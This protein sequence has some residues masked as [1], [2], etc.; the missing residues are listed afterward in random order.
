M[1]WPPSEEVTMRGET[2]GETDL[3]ILI[4]SMHPELSSEQYVFCTTQRNLKEI[5]EWHPWAIITE[6]EAITVIVRRET[7]DE[8][9]LPYESV[10]RRITL[11]VHSSLDAVGLT[12]A[13]S[14]KLTRSGISANMVAGYYHDH[15]FIQNE[16]ADVALHL[17]SEMAEGQTPQ[18]KNR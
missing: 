3:K 13:V 16:K 12:A 15:I 4:D 2:S 11:N 18:G 8:N 5:A 10:F 7:A 17:L 1:R 9:G 6:Q 14:T